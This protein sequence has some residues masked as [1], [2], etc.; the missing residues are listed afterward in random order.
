MRTDVLGNMRRASDFLPP[1]G[2]GFGL[3]FAVNRGPAETASIVSK[4]ESVLKALNV[5][6]ILDSDYRL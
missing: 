1:R 4:G 6:P 5:P 2:H 3:T